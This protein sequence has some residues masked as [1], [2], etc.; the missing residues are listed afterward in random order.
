LICAILNRI[1]TQLAPSA[2]GYLP[3]R[4]RFDTIYG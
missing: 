2:S 1:F 4:I 3:A